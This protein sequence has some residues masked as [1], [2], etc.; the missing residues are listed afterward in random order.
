MV[1]EYLKK[2]LSLRNKQSNCARRTMSFTQK[3][4]AK[5]QPTSDHARDCERYEQE[6][7]TILEALRVID[8]GIENKVK[9]DILADLGIFLP[10][11][12]YR[13]VDDWEPRVRHSLISELYMFDYAIKHLRDE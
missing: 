1:E 4:I 10:S 7:S 8:S 13:S 11:Y 3:G 5:Q 6:R 2:Y 9:K 12:D